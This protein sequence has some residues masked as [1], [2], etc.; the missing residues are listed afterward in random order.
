MTG[1]FNAHIIKL[2]KGTSAGRS[3]PLSLFRVKHQKVDDWPHD[4]HLDHGVNISI[5]NT[6]MF[7]VLRPASFPEDFLPEKSKYNTG[8]VQHLSAH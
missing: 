2:R 8:S 6:I 3:N 4:L 7:M 1:P 5:I